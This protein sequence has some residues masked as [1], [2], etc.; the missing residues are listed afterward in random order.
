MSDLQF[1]DL[2]AAAVAGAALV[3]TVPY[4]CRRAWAATCKS[5]ADDTAWRVREGAPVYDTAGNVW[6]GEVVA[7]GE[8]AESVPADV[9]TIHGVTTTSTGREDVAVVMTQMGPVT[10]SLVRS[11]HWQK[12]QGAA[13]EIARE[14]RCA[15][16]GLRTAL[17]PCYDCG[18]I[19][20]LHTADCDEA[21]RQVS[22]GG[23]EMA[24]RGV[25]PLADGRAINPQ[26][27]DGDEEGGNAAS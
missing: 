12:M 24:A 10:I 25:V 22:M 3:D 7:A 23:D 20:G 2:V 18:E 16:N 9:K 19:G 17:S 15:A 21:A 26:G 4:L 11:S 5:I 13:D 27:H 6:D 1:F 8:V 14:L